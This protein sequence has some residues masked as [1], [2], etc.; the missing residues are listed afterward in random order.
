LYPHA[1]AIG[2]D[3]GRF[4][5]RTAIVRYDG[6]IMQRH[7]FPVEQLLTRKNIISALQAALR[8]TREAATAKGIN[9]L[10]AGISVP[11]YIDHDN[12]IVLGPDHGIRGW[13]NVPLASMMSSALGIPAYAGNDANLMTVA[14]HR[15]GRARGYRH[16][17]FI[18]L[19]TGIGGGIIIDGR[20]YRGVNNSGGEVGMM[21][22]DADA[23]GEEKPGKGTLEEYASGEALVRS[24][25][26]AGG[27]DNSST[28]RVRAKDIFEMSR[29]GNI[30]AR[31]VV[32]ANAR[33][34][35]IGLANISS[36]FA[37]E[38]IVLG[39]GMALAGKEY[40]DLIRKNTALHC[41][42]WSSKGMKIETALLGDDAAVAGAACYALERLDGRSI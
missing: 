19:R 20:L 2:A 15:Y 6:V 38:I 10:A 41:L 29:A 11:G 17:V 9:P 35:G 30:I 16:V 21:I 25:L 27:A 37:P 18:A 14:E 31:Q 42:P 34:I 1:T 7:T 28:G 8:R 40:I 5:V 26:A 22:I 24:Y 23:A 33:Y 32:S 3:L 36:I 13:K 4:A 12:G 39:G